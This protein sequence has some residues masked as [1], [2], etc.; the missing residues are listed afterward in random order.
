MIRDRRG[1]KTPFIDNKIARLATMIN[2][3]AKRSYSATDQEY[4]NLLNNLVW[5]I[6][7]NLRYPGVS[8]LKIQK[9]DRLTPIQIAE[10]VATIREDIASVYDSIEGNQ[11]EYLRRFNRLLAYLRTL[12]SKV[13]KTEN[14]L[15]SIVQQTEEGVFEIGDSFNSQL[16][17]DTD[18]TPGTLMNINNAAGLVTLPL[19]ASTELNI[20]NVKIAPAS[21]GYIPL[22]NNNDIADIYDKNPDTWFQYEKTTGDGKL[23]YLELIISL[24]TNRLVNEIIIDPVTIDDKSFPKIIDIETSVDGKNYR[25]VRNEFPLDFN[26]NEEDKFFTLGPAG[27]RNSDQLDIIFT[28]RSAQYIKLKIQ[29][30]KKTVLANE[31]KYRIAIAEISV[32]SQ[33]YQEQGALQT[34]ELQLP[35]EPLRLWLE[36]IEFETEPLT[37]IEWQAS[38]DKGTTWFTLPVKQTVEI[39]TGSSNSVDIANP[40][41]SIILQATALRNSNKFNGIAR[42][43]ASSTEEIVRRFQVGRPPIEVNLIDVPIEDSLEV[44]RPVYAIGQDYGFPITD[45]WGVT[46]LTVSLPLSIPEFSETLK[47]NGDKYN[48][49]STLSNSQPDDRVYTIDYSNDVIKFGDSKT[50]QTPDGQITLHFDPE[51][52]TLPDISPY[53]FELNYHHDYNPE[54]ISVFWYD[55]IRRKTNEKLPA[56]VNEIQLENYP[57]LPY[58]QITE[59]VPPAAS[60]FY[61]KHIPTNPA[62][63]VFSD[64]STF[65]TLVSG[66]PSAP[67]E[68]SITYL[69]SKLEYN[70]VY[71][72]VYNTTKSRTPGLAIINARAKIKPYS[73]SYT[74]DS[75]ELLNSAQT[76]NQVFDIYEPRFN[77]PNVFSTEKTYIDGNL[78]LTT[79][80]EYSIDYSKGKI[81][82][83]SQ[84]DADKTS[85]ITYSYQTKSVIDWEFGSNSKELKITDSAFQVNNNDEDPVILERIT[86]KFYVI[87]RDDRWIDVP[88]TNNG[89]IF[90][91]GETFEFDESDYIYGEVLA[92]AQKRV[93]LNHKS[94]IKNSIKFIFLS[95][96]INAID[97]RIVVGTTISPRPIKDIYGNLLENRG[98][99]TTTQRD[100]DKN[101]LVR[102][103]DFIDG[104]TELEQGGDYS[105]DYENGILY[106]FNLIPEHTVIQY[107]YTDVRVAYIGCQS[108]QINKDYFFDPNQLKLTIQNVGAPAFGDDELLIKYEAIT[109]LNENPQNILGYY[110][111]ILMGYKLRVRN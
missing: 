16:L 108:F 19:K 11:Q 90:S 74:V 98:F 60:G 20:A 103:R 17:I 84:T 76:L 5:E 109:E 37:T 26:K 79:E 91:N 81:Y 42:P 72:D 105:V 95:D 32:R 65:A 47:V 83:F 92:S 55:K 61:L 86:G 48:R 7:D 85:I 33:S 46:S 34:T 68:Y 70:P 63:I 82:T 62:G 39:N 29:Q 3:M 69:N 51:R 35:F 100:A 80:G 30:G 43:L 64:K 93:K 101:T 28:P 54:N 99:G 110:S 49:V 106:S 25:S 96:D 9:G 50:A 31:E 52:V 6:Y 77:N 21:N 24:K 94:I 56:G 78:E 15:S 41:N 1:I 23:L 4:F 10:I 66:T 58:R 22:N 102:E 73:N 59:L 8:K 36:T 14:V 75:W 27:F 57:I 18:N 45:Q 12:L 71:V 87:F 104:F 44:L 97:D 40:G 111:P 53:S 107:K 13:K 88:V 2:Q 89:T 38:V 67:G